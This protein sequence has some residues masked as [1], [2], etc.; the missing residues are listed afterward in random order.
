MKKN[1]QKEKSRKKIVRQPH[2]KKI[3]YVVESKLTVGKLYKIY[4]ENYL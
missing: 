1:A 2:Y 4:I 3:I